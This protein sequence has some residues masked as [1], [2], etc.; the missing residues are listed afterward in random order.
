MND[1]QSLLVADIGGTNARFAIAHRDRPGF[2][3]VATLGTADFESVE[4]AIDAYLAREC[5]AN[6]AAICIAAAGPV[7]GR[8]VQLTNGPWLVSSDTLAGHFGADQ[9]RLL[10]DFEA[11]AY[12]MPF[13]A[14]K[15]L[16]AVGGSAPH[17]PGAGDFTIGIVGP[18]TGFGA[19]GLVRRDGVL[20]PIAG[21]A[22]HAGFTPETPEQ[23]EVLKALHEVYDRVVIEHLL[24]GPG[25][26][27]LNRALG[28]V[29]GVPP[30][31]DTAARIF[32]KG[33]GDDALAADTVALFFE[34]LGQVAGDLALILGARDGMYVAGGI[35]PRYQDL[36]KASGFR[37]AFE[38]K[39]PYRA[40]ME[41]IPTTLVTHPEPGLLGASACVHD[42]AG[43]GRVSG[44]ML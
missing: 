12:A 14:E 13:L 34:V 26:V 36:L 2:S 15:D 17:R 41:T 33:A 18:G 22:G 35:V 1:Q 32:T 16:C 42:L 28:R 40:L 29:R 9:V 37:R 11:V 8:R 5:L 10:N 27:N 4:A 30:S 23:L 3:S 20:V 19:A 31:A 24:S 21:E 6:P 44:P 38:N 25:I 43:Q 7:A 39:G